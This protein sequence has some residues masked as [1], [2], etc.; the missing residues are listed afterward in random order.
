[1]P[2]CEAV[3]EHVPVVTSVT[4]E[5]EIVHTGTVVE[6][7]VTGNAEVAVAVRLKGVP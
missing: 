7:S 2:A 6:A 3:I 4:V 1:M 5:P